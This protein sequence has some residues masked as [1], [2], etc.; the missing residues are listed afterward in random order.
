MHGFMGN[1]FA[2][3]LQKVPTNCQP[4]PGDDRLEPYLVSS[5]FPVLPHKRGILTICDNERSFNSYLHLSHICQ[6]CFLI[7]KWYAE[8]CAWQCRDPYQWETTHNWLMNDLTRDH[9]MGE[10][11]EKRATQLLE[12]GAPYNEESGSDMLEDWFDVSPSIMR[13]NT[14]RILDCTCC[15]SVD[16]AQD[17]LEEPEFNLIEWFGSQ[18][19]EID[20]WDFQAI[21]SSAEYQCWIAENKTK[22]KPT[23]T[24]SSSLSWPELKWTTGI[25]LN[26]RGMR[27]LSGRHQNTTKT[28]H[29]SS[30]NK[31]TSHSSVSGYWV[32]RRLHVINIS[33]SAQGKKI[34]GALLG[35]Q[36]AIQG[37]WS[38]INTMTEAQFQYQ[39]ID[40]TCHLDIINLNSY[41]I[42]LRTLW[43]YQH[44]VCIGLNPAW[45]VIRQDNPDLIQQGQDT[46]LMVHA[47]GVSKLSVEVARAR[48]Q[49]LA[50]PLCLDV[51]E[52]DLPLFWAINH[53]IPLIDESKRPSKCLEVF[54]KQWAEKWDAYLK[55][56][57]WKITLSGNTVPMLLI[58]KPKTSPPQLRTVVDLH[59]WNENTHWLTLPL[60]DMDSMLRQAVSKP[61]HSVLDLKSTYEQIRIVPEHVRQSTVTTP[62]GN[63]VSQVIQIGNC[64]ALAT[65]QALMNHLFLLYISQFM[66]VYLDDIIIYSDSVEDHIKHVSKVLDILIREKAVF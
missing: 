64:N 35:L 51:D 58:S 30:K 54:R 42:I 33:R 13:V 65:Y 21:L 24:Q 25:I 18:V 56:G 26:C 1:S 45:I 46:K 55:S 38:K 27:A 17:L 3:R 32:P 31:Q 22:I 53:T 34:L 2:E 20:H 52:T 59:E 50:E 63:I 62:D 39:G 47:L 41:N 15:I 28:G 19:L 11:L 66:D 44:R 12:L 4:Y 40:L 10:A 7:G 36:L 49:Q 29:P 60:P 16:I 37:S 43:L 14:F 6:D 9:C 5:C 57:Q 23:V 48:L 8:Q 61:F